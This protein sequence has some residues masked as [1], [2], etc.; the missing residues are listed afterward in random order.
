MISTARITAAVS[1]PG[2]APIRIRIF[3][4]PDHPAGFPVIRFFSALPSAI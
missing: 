1:I 3:P 4:N 2:K